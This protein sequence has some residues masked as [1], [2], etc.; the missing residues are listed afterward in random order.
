VVYSRRSRSA[1]GRKTGEWNDLERSSLCLVKALSGIF[2]EELMQATKNLTQCSLRRTDRLGQNHR[3]LA[4]IINIW[5][6]EVKC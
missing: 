4:R 2:L 5:E 6:G 3:T 1:E